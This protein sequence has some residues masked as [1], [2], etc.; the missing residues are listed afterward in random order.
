[1]ESSKLQTSTEENKMAITLDQKEVRREAE[2]FELRITN[3]PRKVYVIYKH[4][5]FN[6][7][8]GGEEEFRGSSTNT[9]LDLNDQQLASINENLEA[10]ITATLQMHP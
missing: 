7:L 3:E 9:Y 6:V 10:L 8:E 5:S 4:T 2:V 1:M